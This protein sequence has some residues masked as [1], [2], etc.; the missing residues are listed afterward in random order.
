MNYGWI[1][2]I[3]FFNICNGFIN[4]YPKKDPTIV[5]ISSHHYDPASIIDIWHRMDATCHFILLLI[6]SLLFVSLWI[7]PFISIHIS[8]TKYRLTLFSSNKNCQYTSTSIYALFPSFSFSI[9]RSL[10][11]FDLNR[12]YS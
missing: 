1:N 12:Q 6:Y 8:F 3:V 11:T 10:S 4:I 2:E 7:Y 5:D 9:S